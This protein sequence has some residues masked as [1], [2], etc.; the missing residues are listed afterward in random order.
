MDGWTTDG[1]MH[2]HSDV[3]GETIIPHHYCVAEYKEFTQGSFFVSLH[4]S[5]L[6]NKV[7]VTKI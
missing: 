6:G 1:Q 7:K 5:D 2:K 4:C 3:Q